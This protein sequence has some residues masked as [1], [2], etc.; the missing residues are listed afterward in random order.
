MSKKTRYKHYEHVDCLF[1]HPQLIS[2]DK[3]Q[4][5]KKEMEDKIHDGTLKLEKLHGRS[6]NWLS[7][8]IGE[9]VRVLSEVA[10]I[11]IGGQDK[12][13]LTIFIILSHHEYNKFSTKE[14]HVDYEEIIRYFS[15]ESNVVD[16]LAERSLTIHNIR[17]NDKEIIILYSDQLEV[18][19][20]Q[21]KPISQTNS[22]KNCI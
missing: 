21:A 13:C 20:T 17:Y 10:K 1:W 15:Q 2:H 18:L 16:H 8:R 7:F 22:P 11:N 3:Y 6:D 19:N 5:T 12:N 9:R 14:F 4:S